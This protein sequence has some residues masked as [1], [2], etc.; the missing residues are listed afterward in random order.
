MDA[1]RKNGNDIT[2]LTVTEGGSKSRLWNQIKAD[3]LDTPVI[4]LKQT[5]GAVI[6]NAALAAYGVGD[7]ADVRDLVSQWV[8]VKDTYTPDAESTAAY[9]KYSP[10]NEAPQETMPASFALLKELK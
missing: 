9:R 10:C 1:L 5:A 3:C 7:V 4:T 2:R 8:A 6:S